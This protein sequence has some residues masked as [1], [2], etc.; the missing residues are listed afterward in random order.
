M[1]PCPAGQEVI[2]FAGAFGSVLDRIGI[3]CGNRVPPGPVPSATDGAGMS[4]VQSRP[5][6]TASAEPAWFEPRRQ[7]R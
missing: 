7:L 2:G 6:P 1:F 4:S 3:V 5:A